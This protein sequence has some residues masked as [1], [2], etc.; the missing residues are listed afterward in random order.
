ML[1]KTQHD[2]M[3][4]VFSDAHSLHVMIEQHNFDCL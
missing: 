2:D 1:I 3:N 4:S